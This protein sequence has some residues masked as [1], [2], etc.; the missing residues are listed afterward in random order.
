MFER[1]LLFQLGYASS[2]YDVRRN[3]ALLSEHE[4]DPVLV[5]VEGERLLGL[6]ALPRSC[7]AAGCAWGHISGHWRFRSLGAKEQRLSPGCSLMQVSGPARGAGQI[8]TPRHP[9]GSVA[10]S[11]SVG[12]QPGRL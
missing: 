8:T 6:V 3:H 9:D 5:A 1:E 4:S 11:H 7:V 2:K 12:V 10:N